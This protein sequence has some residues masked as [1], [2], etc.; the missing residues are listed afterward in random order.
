MSI[1]SQNTELNQHH[2]DSCRKRD[3]LLRKRIPPSGLDS[4]KRSE[5][6]MVLGRESGEMFRPFTRHLSFPTHSKHVIWVCS[7][8]CMSSA[9]AESPD[10]LPNGSFHLLILM[11]PSLG[12]GLLT[13]PAVGL[14]LF[15]RSSF[16]FLTPH[17]LIGLKPS[18]FSL[19]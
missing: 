10:F 1:L 11:P 8:S 16:I 3:S 14:Q 4:W 15:P 7:S 6:P 17:S 12:P 19:C 2:R 5:T 13:P 9:W 18:R